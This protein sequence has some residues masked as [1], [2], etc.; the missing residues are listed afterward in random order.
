MAEVRRRLSEISWLMRALSEPIARLANKQD[1][2]NG[3]FLEGRFKAQRI[4]DEAGL[5][6]CAM[7]VDLNPVRAAMAESPDKSVHTSAYDR[8]RAECG[9][10]IPSAAFDLVSITADEAGNRLKNTSVDDLKK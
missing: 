9:E 3:R 10:Q 6:A 4:S 1:D 7:Y 5:L 8:I 2:C